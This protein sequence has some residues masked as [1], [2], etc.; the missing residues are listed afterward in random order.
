MTIF[1]D[2]A[3][4]TY[5]E[6]IETLVP[7]YNLVLSLMASAFKTG[8][9]DNSHILVAGCGTGSEVLELAKFLPDAQF[10]AVE[11][12]R[13][14]LEKAKERVEQAGLSQRVSFKNEKIEDCSGSYDAA[15]LS[16]VLHFI[17]FA[18]KLEFLQHLAER[19]KNGGLLLLFDVI[20]TKG[21][22][23]LE[24]WLHMRIGNK[25]EV[26]AAMNHLQKDWYHLSREKTRLLFNQAGFNEVD[27]IFRACCYQLSLWVRK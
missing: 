19:L 7:G 13:G 21:D 1:P 22:K 5:D 10:T 6:R 8:L 24:S 18:K 14:M 9:K 15:T 23:V 3:A 20:E 17:P 4:S 11:A 12:S 26:T 16:L 25:R 27:V 2:E